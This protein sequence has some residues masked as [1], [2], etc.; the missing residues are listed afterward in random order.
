MTGLTWVSP[1]PRRASVSVSPAWK[2]AKWA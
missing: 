2:W 1:N